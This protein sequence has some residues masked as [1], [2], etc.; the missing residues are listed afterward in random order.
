MT[1]ATTKHHSRLL[2]SSKGPKKVASWR[3]LVVSWKFEVALLVLK[4][5]HWS[6][7]VLWSC[8]YDVVSGSCSVL[9]QFAWEAA[10]QKGVDEGR[11]NL[12]G[13]S[14][15]VGIQPLMFDVFYDQE[16]RMNE[17]DKTVL[18]K[19]ETW[20]ENL[21]HWFM[22]MLYLCIYREALL[23]EFLIFLLILLLSFNRLHCRYKICFDNIK[24]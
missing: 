8:V 11:T 14:C 15:I 2:Q 21:K 18:H 3:V 4:D 12:L 20:G 23:V 7:V 17:K 24:F 5:E 1:N 19:T 6:E 13:K 16:T 22:W 10:Q 9:V